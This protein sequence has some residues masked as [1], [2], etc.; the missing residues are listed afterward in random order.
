MQC[1]KW[2]LRWW[3]YQRPS[4]TVR[5]CFGILTSHLTCWVQP[6]QDGGFKQESKGKVGEGDIIKEEF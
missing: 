1:W 4:S 6:W 3:L 2:L 5:T